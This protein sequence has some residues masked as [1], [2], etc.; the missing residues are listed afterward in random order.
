MFC[1]IYRSINAT[2]VRLTYYECMHLWSEWQPRTQRSNIH[3]WC[4]WS[5]GCKQC[6]FDCERNNCNC[7]R[8][9]LTPLIY[10]SDPMCVNQTRNDLKTWR[11]MNLH[12]H[13]LGTGLSNRAV[14]S[15]RAWKKPI[16]SYVD[17]WICQYSFGL[18]LAAFNSE[19]IALIKHQR[20]GRSKGCGHTASECAQVNILRSHSHP[21]ES[22]TEDEKS[23]RISAQN[24]R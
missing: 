9:L 19:P 23:H 22:R 24:S 1:R 18:A 11:N 8:I 5:T 3:M 10:Q 21:V 20:F 7:K 16:E 12:A 14:A 6:C 4:N 15:N 17:F 13:W 2:Y